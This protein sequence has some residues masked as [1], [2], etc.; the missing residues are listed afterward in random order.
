MFVLVGGYNRAKPLPQISKNWPYI[1]IELI[2]TVP[3][4]TYKI[5]RDFV[6]SILKFVEDPIFLTK[7]Y[8]SYITLDT[9]SKHIVFAI[10]LPFIYK[11]KVYNYPGKNEK[12]YL[13]YGDKDKENLDIVKKNYI[14]KP[15]EILIIEGNHSLE[16]LYLK[17]I[18]SLRKKIWEVIEHE[19]GLRYGIRPCMYHIKKMSQNF[20]NFFYFFKKK[21][22]AVIEIKKSDQYEEINKIK[23]KTKEGLGIY[24]NK[25][26]GPI[27]HLVKRVS[28][29]K[30]VSIVQS[31]ILDTAKLNKLYLY[32][33]ATGGLGVSQNLKEAIKSAILEGLERYS[34]T[35]GFIPFTKRKFVEIP[36]EIRPEKKELTFFEKQIINKRVRRIKIIDA[37][38]EKIE[39]V[40]LRN[41]RRELLWPYQLVVGNYMKYMI[42]EPSS[43]GTAIDFD[44]EK[45]KLKALY[46]AIERNSLVRWFY[47]DKKVKSWV[48]D[49]SKLD[50]TLLTKNIYNHFKKKEYDFHAFLIDYLG[51]KTLFVI[52]EKENKFYVGS[53]CALTQAEMLNS[54]FKEVLITSIFLQNLEKELYPKKKE[55]IWCLPQHAL[56][57]FNKNRR[58]ELL[59]Y[60]YS[61]TRNKRGGLKIENKGNLQDVI[62][63]LERA[64]HEVFFKDITAPELRIS[65]LIVIKAL[66][67]GFLD[68]VK[69]TKLVWREYYELKKLK[70]PDFPM[71]FA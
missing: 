48:I 16:P 66:V 12:T 41:E 49:L 8:G 32:N 28:P 11:N 40:L 65:D 58:L 13:I 25:T 50:M 39:W 62:K 61:L 15:K 38:A 54:S 71:P 57:Y 18:E 35:L 59:N 52:S 56:Y 70:V 10:G 53:S 20:F 1:N 42:R 31:N 4:K 67:L 3:E 69:N 29:I 55:N 5:N 64:G 47:G 44:K 34:L 51:L 46:E 36:K 60:L 21:K 9:I 6:K 68:I 37:L 33:T 19:K 2:R 26:F 7:S 17:K 43:T 27:T 45:A 23:E 24:L 14:N 22:K 30:G 63:I